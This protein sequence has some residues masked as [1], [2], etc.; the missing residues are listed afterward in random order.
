[1]ARSRST[2]A[3]DDAADA[4]DAL[5]LDVADDSSLLLTAPT[6]FPIASA[7]YHTA[8]KPAP[9]SSFPS[10]SLSPLGAARTR[11]V[12]RE[13]RRG[14]RIA[15]GG[16]RRMDRARARAAWR[17]VASVAVDVMELVV[18]AGTRGRD[19]ARDVMSEAAVRRDRS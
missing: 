7:P 18:V 12:D 13:G 5:A 4:D 9:T 15:R 14:A 1:M 16:A 6:I 10:E 8:F 19:G 2:V 3:A 11:T 17:V